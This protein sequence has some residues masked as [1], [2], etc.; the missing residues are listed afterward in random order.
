MQSNVHAWSREMVL[1][2]PKAQ[3]WFKPWSVGSQVNIVKGEGGGGGG[4]GDCWKFQY[5]VYRNKFPWLQSICQWSL[6]HFTVKVSNC[7]YMITY[8]NK[9]HTSEASVEWNQ[10][11]KDFVQILVGTA[12][13]SESLKLYL[14]LQSWRPWW[15]LA[16]FSWW[17]H[18]SVW[19]NKSKFYYVYTY[20]INLIFSSFQSADRSSWTMPSIHARENIVYPK[21]RGFDSHRGQANFSA[22]LV[23]MH[24]Q[25]NITHW[26]KKWNHA[27]YEI[28]NCTTKSIL[29]PY[30]V[31]P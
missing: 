17:S 12:D 10:S 23:W 11:D 26:K 20:L 25:S 18:L 16:R 24:T 8:D 13:E 9:W 4:G 19:W 1:P 7:R 2:L 27:Y 5:I 6:Y 29:Y 22:C 30:S 31:Y 28:C 14:I 15:K 21:G 3:C